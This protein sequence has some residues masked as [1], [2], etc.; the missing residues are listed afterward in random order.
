[1]VNANSIKQMIKKCIYEEDTNSKIR[2]FIKINK[3]LPKEFK[4]E[5]P[6]M[7][8]KDY[9]DKRLYSLEAQIKNRVLKNNIKV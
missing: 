8:T 9:I 1:M 4:I 5:S 2:L 6:A 3:L 7:I